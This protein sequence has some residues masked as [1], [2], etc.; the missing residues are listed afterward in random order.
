MPKN[1]L[2]TEL[3]GC[4]IK[5]DECQNAESESSGPLLTDDKDDGDININM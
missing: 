4:C 2:C 1:K 3:F 5:S